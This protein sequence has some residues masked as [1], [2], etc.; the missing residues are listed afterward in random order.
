MWIFG[1]E[2]VTAYKFPQLQLKKVDNPSEPITI[3]PEYTEYEQLFVNIWIYSKNGFKFTVSATEYKNAAA[4]EYLMGQVKQK[5]KA[6]FDNL[7]DEG[8][9]GYK[10]INTTVVD[11]DP[12]KQLYFG[13]VTIRVFYFNT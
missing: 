4:V 1:D 2:P 8:A 3:G 5:L 9:K 10:H 6:D 11:Y 7:F 13:A 12:D